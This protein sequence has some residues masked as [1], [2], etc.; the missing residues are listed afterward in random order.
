MKTWGSGVIAPPF[1]ILALEGR[2]WSASRPGRFTPG[3]I[4]PL[5]SGLGVS[6]RR[7][8]RRG[9]EKNLALAGN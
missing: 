5:D 6:Q 9:E 8:G 4:Y 1:L 2:E 3:E 7:S